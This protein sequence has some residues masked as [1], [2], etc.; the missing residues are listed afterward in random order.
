[1]KELIELNPQHADA[2]NFVGYSFAE[3]GVNLDEAES[4]IRKALA[5]SPNKGYIL[6]S[7]GWVYYKKGRYAEAV[8]LLKEAAALQS[9]DPAVLEHLGDVYRDM[10]D[11]VN[12]LESYN[13]GLKM[14]SDAPSDNPEDMELMTRLRQKINALTQSPDTRS[15]N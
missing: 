12:A 2:L 6:D 11:S 15:Q 8:K 1:M 4:L 5:I 14:L 9:D 10:G 13:R 3:R 7:L